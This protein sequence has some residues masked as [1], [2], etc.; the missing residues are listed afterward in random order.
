MQQPFSTMNEY[1]LNT[2]VR[3]TITLPPLMAIWRHHT[4]IQTGGSCIAA[5]LRSEAIAEHQG[6][7]KVKLIVHP[8]Q[9][10]QRGNVILS[11]HDE[12]FENKAHRIL[13]QR[14]SSR[15]EA[16]G[17]LY[18][19]NI[20]YYKYKIR[21]RDIT[22]PVVRLQNDTIVLPTKFAHL[23]RPIVAHYRF[24][25]K[26]GSVSSAQAATVHVPMHHPPSNI[27]TPSRPPPNRLLPQRIVNGFIE[28]ILAKEE[29]CPI[30]MIPLTK[31]NIC[32]TPC[33]H[34]MSF[35]SAQAWVKLAHTCPVCRGGVELY[36]LQQWKA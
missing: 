22:I 14:E 33:G 27:S 16:N 4:D 24:I 26:L 13:I 2:V 21:C 9:Y 34:T 3:S 12:W 11:T 7:W 19:T 6:I 25:L 15:P 35:E 31:E 30:E 20:M 23:D 32:V 28:G 10:I 17:R 36:E 29:P 8:L 5:L 1:L 18:E